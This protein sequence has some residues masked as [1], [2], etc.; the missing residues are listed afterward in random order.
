MTQRD[1]AAELGKKPSWVA[2]VEQRERR[3]DLVEF[4]AV[5]R[6]T[7]LKEIDLLRTIVADLPRRLEI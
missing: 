6:A 7:G 2:K 4:I 3:L 1:L 5:A